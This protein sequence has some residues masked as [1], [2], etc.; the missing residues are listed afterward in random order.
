MIAVWLCKSHGVFTGVSITGNA[1]WHS[2]EGWHVEVQITLLSSD[3][4]QR[5]FTVGYSDVRNAANSAPSAVV[6][7]RGGWLDPEQ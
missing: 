5:C 7:G 4:W 6:S 2:V 3:F 1:E